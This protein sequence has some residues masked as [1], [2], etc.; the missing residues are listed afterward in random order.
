MTKKRETKEEHM[1]EFAVV[2]KMLRLLM[3]SAVLL[4]LMPN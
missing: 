4:V 2:L 3:L 1:T